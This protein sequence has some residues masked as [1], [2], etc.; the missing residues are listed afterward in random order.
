MKRRAKSEFDG[1]ARTYDRSIVQHLLFRPAYRMFMEELFRWRRDL[2]ESF[3]LLDIGSGTGTWTARVA[4]SVMP[5]RLV[6]GLDYSAQM[7]AVATSKARRIGT[8]APAFVN[9]DAEHLPFRGESFDVL[10][11]SHSLHH[12]PRQGAAI[13]EMHRVLRPGGRLMI[14]DGFRDNAIGWFL[15]DVMI[16]RAESTPEAKVHHASW[17]A[18]RRY[19]A[20]AGFRHVRQRKASIWAPIML[21]VGV[22]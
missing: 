1:W 21:T 18:M 14:I 4:G 10:T 12:Y 8:A 6:F 20:E 11:C 5:A 9:G 19:F 7:C 15:F 17:R 22:V 13:R 3:D 16:T 2:R